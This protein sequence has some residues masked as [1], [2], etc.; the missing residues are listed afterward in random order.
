VPILIDAQLRE[1]NNRV[2][3]FRPATYKPSRL[4]VM[5][6][7]WTGNENSMWIFTQKLS[8]HYS[9]LAPRGFF[10]ASEGG[11][12]WREIPTGSRGLPE[13]DDLQASAAVLFDFVDAWSKVEKLNMDQFDLIGFS[14]G[15]ALAYVMVLLH[16]ERIRMLAAL[17]GFLP[18][19]AEQLLKD[20]QLKRKPVFISH[21]RQDELVPVDKAR[22]AVAYFKEVDANVT[23]CESEGGHKVSGECLSRV[24]ELF[25]E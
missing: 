22:K 5:L 24:A 8:G 21:G 7:G 12:S 18:E 1:F 17:S 10:V 11:F 20:K 9:I 14:Q 3:R 15:A 25:G 2:F 23:Y 19:G 6:H 4:L 13:V 16:P